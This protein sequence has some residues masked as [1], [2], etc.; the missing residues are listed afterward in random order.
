MFGVVAS[1]LVLLAGCVAPIEV[2]GA[3]QYATKYAGFTKEHMVDGETVHTLTALGYGIAVIA[4]AFFVVVNYYGVRWFA[5]M[6]L[7]V[8]PA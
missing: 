6:I 5:R 7:N 1:V 8:T 4:M 2:E 3:L